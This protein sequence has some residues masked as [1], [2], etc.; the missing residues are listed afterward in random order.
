MAAIISERGLRRPPL[1]GIMPREEDAREGG[2]MFRLQVLDSVDSTNE[3]IKRAIED[4]EPEGLG[5]QVL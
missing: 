3:V 4:D 1:S 5:H 2:G